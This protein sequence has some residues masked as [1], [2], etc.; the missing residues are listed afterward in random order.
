MQLLPPPVSDA[1]RPSFEAPI[2]QLVAK[3]SIPPGISFTHFILL[4]VITYLEIIGNIF[5][6]PELEFKHAC[7]LL[8]PTILAQEKP[9]V[10][11]HNIYNQLLSS[12]DLSGASNSKSYN[13]LLTQRWM[14]VVPRSN[15][16]YGSIFLESIYFSVFRFAFV[17]AFFASFSLFVFR[18]RFSILDFQS[19]IYMFS[20]FFLKI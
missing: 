17:F 1:S 16:K 4:I 2:E 5:R 18:F 3:V 15:E 14:L 20:I 7:L 6:I 11:L 13:L 19:S 8:D 9:E 12:L 10:Y